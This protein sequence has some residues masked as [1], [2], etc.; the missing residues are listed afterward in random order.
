[1]AV[2]VETTIVIDRPRAE[3]AVYASDPD[4]APTWYENIVSVAWQTPRPMTVGSRFAFV[5]RF[6]G[7]T[8]A[9]SYEV[10]ELVP[11]ERFVMSTSEGPFPMETNYHWEDTPR[12]WDTDGAAQPR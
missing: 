9:Y 12:W 6:L 2:D 3:V 11:G 4:H 8:F 7:R 1:M 10:R 5:A